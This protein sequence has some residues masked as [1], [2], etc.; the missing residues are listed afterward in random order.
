MKKL[1]IILLFAPTILFAQ[2]K[3]FGVYGF[4]NM[5]LSY[6]PIIIL[7]LMKFLQKIHLCWLGFITPVLV[8]ISL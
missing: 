2:E 6:L 5:M 1:S 7:L 4:H 3:G 8:K